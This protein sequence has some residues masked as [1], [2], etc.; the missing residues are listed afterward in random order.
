MFC[1][2]LHGTQSSSVQVRGHDLIYDFC[3]YPHMS[4]AYPETCCMVSTSRDNPVQ[5]WDS[6]SGLLRCTYRAYDD[7]VCCFLAFCRFSVAFVVLYF[8]DSFC[9]MKSVNR[10]TYWSQGVASLPHKCPPPLSS[11][12]Q[13]PSYGDCLEVKREYYQNCSL[14]GCVTQCSQ[15]AAHLYE[16]FL[17]VQQIGF[18]TLGPLRHA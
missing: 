7:M 6:L 10:I 5:L 3:W 4:S 16:Q 18:V 8:I 11:A 2:C 1:I 14:L 13:H 9:F 12:R 17:Q 15:S